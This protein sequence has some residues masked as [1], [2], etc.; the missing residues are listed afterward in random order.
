MVLGLLWIVSANAY[1]ALGIHNCGEVLSK[2]NVVAKEMIKKYVTGYFTGRNYETNGTVGR[3]AGSDS[4]YW[5]VMKYCKDNPLKDTN[6][7][8]EDVYRQLKNK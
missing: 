5:A 7:A 2:E 3:G 8:V 6:D 4:L 1:T